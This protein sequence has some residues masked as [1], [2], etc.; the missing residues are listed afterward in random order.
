MRPE[1]DRAAALLRKYAISKPPVPVE[2]IAAGEGAVIVRNHFDGT[3]SGFTLRDGT[4]I[5]IGINTR[6]SKKRQRFSI[7]HELGHVILHPL[8]ALIVDHAVRIDWRDDVSALGT[9]MQE[10]EANAFGA[11]LL[12]PKEMVFMEIKEYVSRFE[13][14]GVGL[15]R[16]EF[17]S[18]LARTFDVST[19]AMGFRLI[20]LG[21]LAA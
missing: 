21:I 1:D 17:T 16:E 3:E 14:S 10:V 4:R 5:I 19:E 11:A 6:T 8:S 13:N 15:T 20:N 7:A 9:D 12:M 18:E 2:D